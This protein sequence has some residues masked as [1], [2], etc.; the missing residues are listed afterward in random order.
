MAQEMDPAAAVLYNEGNKL[1]KAGSFKEAIVKYDSALI[2]VQDYR[3][4]NGKGIAYTRAKELDSAIVNYEKAISMSTDSSVT[5]SA[6]KNVSIAYYMLGNAISKK[7]NKKGLEYL[8]KAVENDSLD[9]AYLSLARVYSELSQF[10][11][12]LEAAENALKYKSKISEAGPYYYMGLAYKGKKDTKKAKE[13][14]TN[15]ISDSTYGKSAKSE[16]DQ[17]K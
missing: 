6:K 14:F 12:T 1:L 7:N 3:I 8:Q 4:Y 11:K 5:L 10:D 2:I 17:L 9:I 13:M 16:L 15:A